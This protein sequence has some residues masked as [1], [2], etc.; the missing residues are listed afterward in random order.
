MRHD[1]LGKSVRWYD[2]HGWRYGTVRIIGY[3]WATL[4][5]RGESVRVE[6]ERLHVGSGK[7]AA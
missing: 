7:V 2:E 6:I 3:K 4:T 5:S 1:L